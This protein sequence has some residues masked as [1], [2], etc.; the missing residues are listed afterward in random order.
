MLILKLNP[1]EKSGE[2]LPVRVY[3]SVVGNDARV[4]FKQVSGIMW[5]CSYFFANT[6]KAS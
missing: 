5:H 4:D 6:K 1:L 3:E 2:R